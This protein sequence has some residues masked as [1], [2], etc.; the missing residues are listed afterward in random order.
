MN[1]DKAE[2]DFETAKRKKLRYEDY[3]EGSSIE[4]AF[5][6]GKHIEEI[7]NNAFAKV[8]EANTKVSDVENKV[9]EFEAKIS[10]IETAKNDIEEKYNQVNAEFEEMKPKYEDFVKAEQ[11]RI[12]AELEAK[13]DAEFAKYETVLADE[14]SFAALKEK[15]NEMTFEQIE[16]ECAIMYAR[17]SLAT[18]FSKS[19]CGAM[20]AGLIDEDKKDGLVATKYGYV[21]KSQ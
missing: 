17:K 6:F 12:D 4:G 16:S 13:K 2:I 20:N 5:D 7:E 8:E 15:K 1:G 18:N 9:V 11:A 19:D 3:E 21:R 10:E 14:V